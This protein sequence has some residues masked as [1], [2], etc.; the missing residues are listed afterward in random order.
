LRQERQKTFLQQERISRFE[1]GI[2]S[3]MQIEHEQLLKI[4]NKAVKESIDVHNFKTFESKKSSS[5]KEI[6]LALFTLGKFFMCNESGEFEFEDE[7]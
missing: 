3:S 1:I 6:A 7:N 4:P 5:S 2:K